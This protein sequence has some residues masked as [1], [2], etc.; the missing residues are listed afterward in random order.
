MEK[1]RAE[2]ISKTFEG[3]NGP[4]LALDDVSFSVEEGEFVVTIT[5]EGDDGV[6]VVV[7]GGETYHFTPIEMEEAS[8]IVRIN[9]E[10][11][12]DINYAE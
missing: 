1:L 8:I 5:E 10:G 7:E 12:G 3:Q 11:A 4:V 9:T 2:H 6:Q